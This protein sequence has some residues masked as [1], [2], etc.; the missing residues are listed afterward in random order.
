MTTKKVSGGY[1]RIAQI[2]LLLFF[3]PFTLFLTYIIF[4]KN[5]TV[6][7][8]VFLVGFL[9]AIFLVLKF[10]F[11]YADIYLSENHILIKKLFTTRKNSLEK[12]SEIN[13]SFFPFTYYIKVGE[14]KIYFLPKATDLSKQLLSFNPD[15][16]LELIKEKLVK[17]NVVKKK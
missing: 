8:G 12:I 1:P 5:L 14:S 3:V 15:K 7:G 11:S 6:E 9:S 4:S 10:G 13:E 16:G 2:M 17:E